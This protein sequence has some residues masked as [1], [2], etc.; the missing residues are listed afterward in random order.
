LGIGPHVAMLALTSQSGV[1][2]GQRANI[3]EM[4]SCIRRLP[5]V[6]LGR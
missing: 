5:L 3:P 2:A 1:P 4:Y 6:N